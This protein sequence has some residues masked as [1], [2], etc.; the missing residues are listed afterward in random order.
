[1]EPRDQSQGQPSQDRL[2]KWLD[3]ALHEYGSAEP[4]M[5]LEGLVLANLAAEQVR[6]GTRRWWVWG[7]VAATACVGVLVWVGEMNHRPAAGNVAG[8]AISAVPKVNEVDRQPD[9]GRPV[10]ETVQRRTPPRSARRI[11]VAREPRLSQFPS[12]RPLSEQERLLV[13][14]VEE[15]PDEAVLIAKEQAGRRKEMEQVTGDES[16]KIGS[17]Q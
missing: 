14:Y 8:N 7:T 6:A 4:R 5:G 12:P 1:M 2:D 16:S 11:E 10:V 15:S 9:V 13:R 3:T 17:D